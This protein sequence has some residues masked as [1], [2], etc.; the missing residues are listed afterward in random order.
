MGDS[1]R[2][3]VRVRVGVRAGKRERCAQEEIAQGRHAS[4]M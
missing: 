2:D 3:G 4:G 1:M